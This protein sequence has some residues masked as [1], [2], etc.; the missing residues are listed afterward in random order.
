MRHAIVAALA[1]I[2]LWGCGEGE[3]RS[4]AGNKGYS[5]AELELID[6]A[7]VV[8]YCVYGAV[9]AAQRDGCYENVSGNDV[10]RY[11]EG[12][13]ATNAGRYGTGD[14]T[15]CLADSGPFCLEDERYE[16]TLRELSILY[17][18]RRQR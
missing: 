13:D 14:M 18:S 2:A 12:K 4:R 5:S 7:L 8:R 15:D 11:S 17:K 1:V 9:S 6:R 10:I 16:K 3:S